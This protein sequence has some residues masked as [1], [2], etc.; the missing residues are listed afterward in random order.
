MNKKEELMKQLAEIEKQERQSLIEAEYPKFASLI[1]KCFK[2][3]DS[4]SCPKKPSD[5]WFSYSKIISITPNDIYMGG[6]KND[7][8]LSSCIVV[9][10]QTDKDG[11]FKISPHYYT[12]VHT[13]G[14]EININEFNKEFDKAVNRI[15]KILL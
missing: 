3:R 9:T 15:K 8:V 4:Y 2:R 11:V 14:E 7:K 12:Y 10:F 1:G 6:M 5:Y 13:L